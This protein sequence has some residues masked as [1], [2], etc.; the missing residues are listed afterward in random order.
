MHCNCDVRREFVAFDEE[1]IDREV[2]AL[3]AKDAAKLLTLIDFYE[4]CGLG[5]PNPVRIDGYGDGTSGS[6]T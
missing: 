6:G 2:D 3:P 1:V 5:D 4:T